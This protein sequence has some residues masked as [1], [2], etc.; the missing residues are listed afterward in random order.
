MRLDERIEN[1]FV[2]IGDRFPRKGLL[3]RGAVAVGAAM[4]YETSTAEASPYP[5]LQCANTWGACGGVLCC[6]AWSGCIAT[7]PYHCGNRPA[8]CYVDT[9]HWSRCCN[10]YWLY[11]WVDCCFLRSDGSGCCGSGGDP[12]GGSVGCSTC[13]ATCN[14]AYCGCYR[15]SY[16]A[17]TAN[18]C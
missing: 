11:Q 3:K 9:G 14:A 12:D 15:C 18:A 6:G 17:I 4:G 8:G 7:T 2:Y 13:V 16:R 5:P 10:G 1:S